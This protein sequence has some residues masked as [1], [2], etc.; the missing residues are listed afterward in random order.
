DILKELVQLLQLDDKS[1]GLLFK[2]L[3][4]RENLGST[5]TLRLG[6]VP[7]GEPLAA[8]RTQRGASLGSRAKGRICACRTRGSPVSGERGAPLQNA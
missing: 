3:K 2:M 1:Q 6:R 4:R 7:P 5:L 8:L